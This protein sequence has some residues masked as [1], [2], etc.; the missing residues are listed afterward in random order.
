MNTFE[1][2]VE[3]QAVLEFKPAGD[4]SEARRKLQFLP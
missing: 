4:Q 1:E 3:I 2:A